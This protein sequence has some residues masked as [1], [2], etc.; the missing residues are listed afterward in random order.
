MPRLLTLHGPVSRRMRVKEHAM[1]AIK[2]ILL[3]TDFTRLAD[4]AAAYAR[5][6]AEMWGA[7]L[8][9]LHVAEPV[10][11]ALPT[12]ETGGAAMMVLPNEADLEAALG[13]FI[14]AHLRGVQVPVVSAV[15]QGSR[16]TMVT[17]YAKEKGI[18]LI[19]IGTHARGVVQRIIFGSMSKSVLEN[20]HCPVLMVPLAAEAD[21]AEGAERQ[22]Q[23]L[24]DGVSVA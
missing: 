21:V 15:L 3:P 22:G 17:S 6:L 4:H 19:V 18:D 8:H 12:P 7:E 5:Q 2:K 23:T 10:A 9:I 24:A 1:I 16:V 13:R 20:A 14:A 11:A